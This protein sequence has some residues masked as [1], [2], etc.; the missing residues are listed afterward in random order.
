MIAVSGHSPKVAAMH[1]AG[2]QQ[3]EVQCGGKQ[4][5][6]WLVGESLLLQQLKAVGALVW[7]WTAGQECA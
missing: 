6:Q 3:A 2:E 7:L 1:H 4:C 5:M